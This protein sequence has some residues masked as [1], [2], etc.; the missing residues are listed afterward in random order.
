[1][2][3]AN[4]IEKSTSAAELDQNIQLF[5]EDMFSRAKKTS[6]LTLDM[7]QATF[8]TPG[9]PRNGIER[10]LLRA[11]EKELGWWLTKLCTPLVF[12]YYFVFKLIW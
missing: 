3:L 8:F 5:E 6:Q 9:S 12:A 4:A 10:Y 1:M 11:A 2:E 7:M